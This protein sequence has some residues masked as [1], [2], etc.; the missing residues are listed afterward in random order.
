MSRQCLIKRY[1]CLFLGLASIAFGIALSIKA[2]LGISPVSSVPYVVSLLTPLTVG[3][4]TILLHC[5]LV[6]LQFLLL[7][8]RFLP[9][10]LLE[11][12]AGIVFGY[13][14]D[15]AIWAT[16]ALTP[17]GYLQRWGFCLIG[18]FFI[19]LGVS[20][21]LLANVLMLATEGLV[22]AIST[23]TGKKTGD[24]KVSIDVSLV[25][26]ACLLSLLFLRRLAGVRE[27]TAAAALLIGMLSKPITRQLK[28]AEPRLL[29]DHPAGSVSKT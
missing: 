14:T 11:V 7:R 21:E 27:G 23:V 16:S 15:L 6:A 13:L 17:S 25:L 28:K 4:V 18:I 26:I 29:A 2:D 8:K 5:A 24:V 9:I 1:I 19:A 10:Y 22:M 3:N 12:P 20:L